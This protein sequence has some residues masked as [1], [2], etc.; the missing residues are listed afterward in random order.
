MI[1][2]LFGAVIVGYLLMTRNILKPR[3]FVLIILLGLLCSIVNTI[4]VIAYTSKNS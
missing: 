3:F 2:P 4:I 1:S